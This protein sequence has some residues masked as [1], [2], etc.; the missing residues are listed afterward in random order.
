ML[1]AMLTLL[2]TVS[3]TFAATLDVC[4][5][6]CTYSTIQ[7]AV[8]A[9][10]SGDEILVQDGGDYAAFRIQSRSD[11]TLRSAADVRPVIGSLNLSFPGQGALGL[12]EDS[13]GI[14]IEGF[15]VVGG[16]N[17]GFTVGR[18]TVAF[19]DMV[20]PSDSINEEGEITH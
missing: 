8:D 10:V 14:V 12:I 19:D 11:I 2:L 20:I 9:S 3:S 1:A 6:G 4:E 17:R 13:S 15:E 7:G 5:T 18:S 16:V